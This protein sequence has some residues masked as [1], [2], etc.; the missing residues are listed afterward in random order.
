MTGIEQEVYEFVQSVNANEYATEKEKAQAAELLAGL[1]DYYQDIQAAIMDG[2]ICMDS[3]VTVQVD[4]KQI[5]FPNID[6]VAE[7]LNYD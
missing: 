1:M 5:K 3:S 2:R 7:W 4:G 6:K